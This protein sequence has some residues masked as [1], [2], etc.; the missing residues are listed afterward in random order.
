MAILQAGAEYSGRRPTTG[1]LPQHQPLLRLSLCHIARGA[2]A[3][4]LARARKCFEKLSGRPGRYTE[5]AETSRACDCAR[6]KN[7]CE[8]IACIVRNVA[9]RAGVRFSVERFCRWSLRLLF[10]GVCC[11]FA[12][13]CCLWLKIS[14]S[15]NGPVGTKNGGWPASAEATSATTPDDRQPSTPYTRLGALGPGR[16]RLAGDGTCDYRLPYAALPTG[17][18]NGA[19]RSPSPSPVRPFLTSPCS[20]LPT[21]H[22][23]GPEAKLAAPHHHAPGST[24]IQ[25]PLWLH[26]DACQR[27][28]WL[29]SAFAAPLTPRR[30]EW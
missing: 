11:F 4:R 25:T 1:R 26:V 14:K 18:K 12:R 10:L 28:L 23:T 22:A 8:L 6:A 17:D 24:Y 9:K 20:A 15:Q 5:P 3:W 13:N 21:P 16:A 19:V 27:G 7:Y 2:A 29:S 30:S